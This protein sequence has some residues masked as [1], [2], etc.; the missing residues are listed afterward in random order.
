MILQ[1]SWLQD[2]NVD[3]CIL[4]QASLC[5]R[6]STRA[7]KPDWN[8]IFWRSEVC[9]LWC[10]RLLFDCKKDGGS[11]LFWSFLIVGFG[12]VGSYLSPHYPTIPTLDLGEVLMQVQHGDV[13]ATQL[14]G[15]D[16]LGPRSM[17][18]WCTWIYWEGIETAYN[19][20]HLWTPI[21]TCLGS[22]PG[23]SQLRRRRNPFFVRIFWYIQVVKLNAPGAGTGSRIACSGSS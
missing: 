17:H 9:M 15:V 8:L 7:W 5:D 2:S 14:Q 21:R 23:P 19:C 10:A 16:T 20:I 18:F 3:Y 11:V 12:F 6:M 13:Y 22:C 4:I 1:N